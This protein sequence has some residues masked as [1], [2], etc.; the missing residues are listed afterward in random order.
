MRAFLV[1]TQ[2]GMHAQVKFDAERA[3]AA[4]KEKEEARDAKKKAKPGRPGVRNEAL[5]SF[6]DEDGA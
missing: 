1:I 3:K 4:R 2:A 5:L 6:N